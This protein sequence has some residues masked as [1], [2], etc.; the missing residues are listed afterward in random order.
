MLTSFTDTGSLR[1]WKKKKEVISWIKI[2]AQ[3]C[4]QNTLYLKAIA[5]RCWQRGVSWNHI[6]IA[7]FV[8]CIYKYE[9]KAGH[10]CQQQQKPHLQT[11]P[12]TSEQKVPASDSCKLPIVSHRGRQPGLPSPFPSSFL[13]WLSLFF[14]P[15]SFFPQA[16]LSPLGSPPVGCSPTLSSTSL[17]SPT[18]FSVTLPPSSVRLQSFER[19][20]SLG[21]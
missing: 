8:N 2:G 5:D 20:F 4:N 10:L 6:W 18:S 15:T 21:K 13:P 7:F 17:S 1:D 3:Q 16:D 9:Q 12:E 11:Q 14:L 19:N